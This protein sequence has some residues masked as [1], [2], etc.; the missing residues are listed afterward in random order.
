[1]I[2]AVT[3]ASGF[4]GTSLLESLARDGHAL[5][6]L[7]RR[8]RAGL[9]GSPDS[10]AWDPATEPPPES[11][12]GAN[13]VI[14]LAGEPVAQRW[15]AQ[16]K[17]RILESRAAGTR[18]LVR[19]LAK[20]ERRPAILVSAS[21]IG[22][23]GSRGDEALDETSEPGRGFLP[24]VCVAWEKEAQAAE[25][26]GIRVALVRIGVVLDPRGGAL[27]RMLPPFR[28]GVG[29]PLGTGNQ[30]MSWI[31][32]A[33]LIGMI[34]FVAEQRLGGAWN[35]TSPMP[36]TNAEFSRALGQALRRPAILPAP[37]LALKL[38]FGE[39]AEVLLGSQRVLPRAAERAGFRFQYPEVRQ[40]MANLLAPQA[41]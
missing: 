3:G 39:M 28:M 6:V 18:N 20:L 26:L 38:A 9:P 33:D 25:A 19:A 30:W 27:A 16:A 17:R 12:L 1:V 41:R 36:V 37:A 11:L 35:A 23:Y 15:T 7:S 5:R 34:R 32:L 14:H 31:H 24:E 4:I 22:Y 21:A 2:V 10:F 8:P 40:A 13:A 29:G